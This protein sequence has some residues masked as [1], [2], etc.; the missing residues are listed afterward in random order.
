MSVDILI[1]KIKKTNNP[2][3]AGLDPKVEYVPE[4]IRERAYAEYGKTLRGACEAACGK[5][6]AAPIL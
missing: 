6:S 2:S 5:E 1:E 4:H 3:V